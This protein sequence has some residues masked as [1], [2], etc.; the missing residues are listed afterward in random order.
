MNIFSSSSSIVWSGKN[1]D[2]KKNGEIVLRKNAFL[3]NNIGSISGRNKLRVVG[4]K[5]TGKGSFYVKIISLSGN[6]LFVEKISFSKRNY[7]EI[8]VNFD[9]NGEYDSCSLVLEKEKDS[10]G[11]V[12]LS[13]IAISFIS[14][15]IVKTRDSRLKKNKL[16]I[17]NS[18][19]NN[20][21]KK[22]SYFNDISRRKVAFIVPYSIYGGAEVY[23]K[24]IIDNLD[25][26]IFDITI[27]YMKKNLLSVTLSNKNVK[28]NIVKTYEHLRAMLIANN[29]NYLVY[30]NS[31]N[32][33]N[34]IKDLMSID[35]CDSFVYEIYHSDFVWS[36]ALSRRRR[37]NG[38][39]NIISISDNLANDIKNVCSKV[40]IPVGIDLSIF[41]KYDKILK[42]KN[43]E[44]PINKNILIGIKPII[45]VV[46]RISKEK[47]IE[48]VLDLAK[49]MPNYQFVV[50]GDGPGKN[51][52]TSKCRSLG[53][54]N[55]T[56][57]GYVKNTYDYYNIFDAFLLPTKCL[58][59]TPISILE[60]MACQVPVF[61]TNYGNI[62]DF[63]T[64]GSTGFFISLNADSDS[65][66][67]ADNIKNKDVI[68]N[69]KKYVENNHNILDISDAFSSLLLSNGSFHKKERALGGLLVAGYYA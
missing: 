68:F 66:T 31:Y 51:T 55:I 13:K 60:A 62:K 45:G 65:K 8:S 17:K 26:N 40:T 10:F 16:S 32:V 11:T 25:N 30:Y 57:T 54:K 9:I 37:R 43:K 44:V 2:L 23:I 63:I 61:T 7:S 34:I 3:K 56:F 53:I 69:A 36:D 24:N 50:V 58:E 49:A 47:N 48:Y 4:R 46:S 29:Y 6:V 52:L 1:F 39:S 67:I 35:A 14:N 19:K 27:L 15:E 28:H 42:Y 33:Y 64:D 5:R 21:N 59:G 18:L 41:K 20:V 22:L 12:E 38:F